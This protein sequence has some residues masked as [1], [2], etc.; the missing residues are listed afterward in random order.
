MSFLDI[1]R[2]AVFALRGNWMRCNWLGSELRCPSGRGE[3]DPL[4]T[5]TTVLT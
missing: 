3:E 5:Q 2:T 4:S 1:L